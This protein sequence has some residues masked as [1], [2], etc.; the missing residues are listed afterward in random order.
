MRIVWLTVMTWKGSSCW[1]ASHYYGALEWKEDEKR[2]REEVSYPISA[3]EALERNK[4][5]GDDYCPVLG[6]RA[7]DLTQRFSDRGHPIER[8]VAYVRER[9]PDA[10]LLE[11]RVGD[12][13]PRPIL[14]GPEE[15]MQEGNALVAEAETAGWW[16]GDEVRMRDVSRR[17]AAFRERYGFEM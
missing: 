13:D 11:G 6:Y 15:V 5:D 12:Y 9:M 3:S 14:Y 1:W 2:M 7:G 4:D 8:A 16:E 17:W 10:V